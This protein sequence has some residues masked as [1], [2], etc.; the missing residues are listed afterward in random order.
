MRL[1]FEGGHTRPAVRPTAGDWLSALDLAE[2]ELTPCPANPQHH[3]PRCSWTAARGARRHCSRAAIPF[4]RWRS[5]AVRA[6]K[7]DEA[8]VAPP[9]VHVRESVPVKPPGRAD[10]SGTDA[11][12]DRAASRPHAATKRP[13]PRR[14]ASVRRRLRPALAVPA[15]LLP[16]AATVVQPVPVGIPDRK[17]PK[18]R[19]RGLP[20]W[21]K[22]MAGMGVLALLLGGCRGVPVPPRRTA[23]NGRRHPGRRHP[24]RRDS[25]PGALPLAAVGTGGRPR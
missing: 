4:P 5:C 18:R 3:Y 14:R 2:T 25:K 15:V 8:A 9:G 21:V 17:R 11:T 12:T 23:E 22:L 19:P 7:A 13:G 1:C 20:L 24:S 10:R 16:P 6:A